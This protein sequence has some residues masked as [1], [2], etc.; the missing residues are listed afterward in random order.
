MQRSWT[1]PGLIVALVSAFVSTP[2]LAQTTTLSLEGTGLVL[3]RLQTCCAE[4]SW[5]EAVAES[6]A[7]MRSLGCTVHVVD[8]KTQKHEARQAELEQLTRS[9][10]ADCALRIVGRP[11]KADPPRAELWCENPTSEEQQFRSI[12][13]AGRNAEPSP[14]LVA[15][16]VVELLIAVLDEVDL[17]ALAGRERG[18]TVPKPPISPPQPPQTQP[19]EPKLGIRLGAQA[20]GSPG[21]TGVMG[22]ACLGLRFKALDQ[23]AFEIDFTGGLL[24]KDIESDEAS[25][26]LDV[27]L[28]RAWVLWEP[29]RS[30][31]FHTSVGLG[32]GAAIVLTQGDSGFQHMGQTSVGSGA[33]LGLG[34]QVAVALTSWL[35]LRA[36]AK[37]GA[38]VPEVSIRFGS[39]QAARF[40]QPFFEGGIGLVF[41]FL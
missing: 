7:E 38:I 3:V 28:L 22:G 1:I 31:F 2:A 27:F 39:D 30:S 6:I 8:G 34:G 17:R 29:K 33:Y 25:S 10:G 37:I 23:L 19:Q 36:E 32:L 11:G 12:R 40:G 41:R 16:K 4:E 9:H 35:A 14:K 26:S 21:G 18:P 13:L 24:A 5:A 20:M 15:L